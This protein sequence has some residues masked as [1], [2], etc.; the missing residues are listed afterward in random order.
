MQSVCEIYHNAGKKVVVVL[1]VGGVCE[2]SSWRDHPDA[3]LLAWQP[4]QEGG[5]AVADILKGKINPSGK[6]PDTF[7]LKYEDVPSAASFPGEPAD[8]PV[9]SFYTEGIYVGYRYYD[10]FAKPAAYDFGYGL[11]YTTFEY[12]D[13]TLSSVNFDKT[14]QVTVTVRNS[15]KTAGK[16]VVQLYLAAPQQ[17]MEKPVQELKGFA[18]TRLLQPGESQRITFTLD[19]HALASFQSGVSAWVAEAGSYE[20]RIGASCKDIRLKASF[21][22]AEPIMVEKVN[23][24]LYPNFNMQELC[25]N[26]GKL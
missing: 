16:E 13:L 26:S 11:S 5:H 21:N 24:I 17:K 3:I 4:G 8:N 23:D 6:L 7:P 18:K 2:T 20:A 10:T 15:G 19:P 22:L 1:N 25:R 14:L 12:S 9:N